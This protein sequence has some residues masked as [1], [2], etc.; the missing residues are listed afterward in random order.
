MIEFISEEHTDKNLMIRAVKT[1]A[2]GDAKAIADYLALKDHWHVTPWLETLLI[3]RQPGFKAM[4][5]PAKT[6]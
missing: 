5:Y 3:E 1:H 4:L 6:T 2:T